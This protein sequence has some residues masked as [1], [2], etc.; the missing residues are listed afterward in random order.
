MH[1]AVIW[2]LLASFCMDCVAAAT[3]NHCFAGTSPAGTNGAVPTPS[4]EFYFYQSADGQC[5]FLHP[6]VSRALLAHYGS[7]AACPPEVSCNARRQFFICWTHLSRLHL[8]MLCLTHGCNAHE[9]AVHFDAY[10]CALHAGGS[11]D[12]CVTSFVNKTD[13][14]KRS[15]PSDLCLQCQALVLAATNTT[16]S[17]LTGRSDMLCSV[18]KGRSTH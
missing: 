8:H 7:Y 16:L 14:C 3:L 13:A 6:L 10:L 18:H 1:F 12:L 15:Q 17:V 4:T 2:P 11:R 5:V 9:C